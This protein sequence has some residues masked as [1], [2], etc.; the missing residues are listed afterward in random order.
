VTWTEFEAQ[1]PELAA[2]V[3]ARFEAHN[4]LLIA[5]LRRDGA[6]RL[7]GIEAT[8]APPRAAGDDARSLKAR[9]PLRTGAC[10]TARADPSRPMVA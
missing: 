3:R 5:T 4:H 10:C 8:V 6:P 1:A 2:R 7:S 9:D